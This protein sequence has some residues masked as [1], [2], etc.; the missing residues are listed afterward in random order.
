MAGTT[1]RVVATARK[2][3]TLSY[4]P[5]S[6]NVL[7]LALDVTSQ[8]S[9]Q[10]ALS[11]APSKFG[12]IDVFVNNAGYTYFGDTESAEDGESRRL[13]DTNFWG[14]VDISKAAL[15]ILRDENPKTGQRGGVVMQVSSM[16]GRKAVPGNAFY[17]ATKFALEGFTESIAQETPP[18][19]NIHFCLIEPGGIK[20]SYATSSLV[21]IPQHPLYTDPSLPTNKLKAYMSDPNASKNWAEPKDIAEVMYSTVKDGIEGANGGQRGIPLRLALGADSWAFMKAGLEQNLKELDSFKSISFKTAGQEQ[22]D[23]IKDFI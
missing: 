13:M 4:L 1:N 16:G 10:E 17:H 9:I 6:P 5:D 11:A 15:A 23:S 3:S 8:S 19:W 14:A 22:L 18:E 20:T 12:R 21:P 2:P 7:K